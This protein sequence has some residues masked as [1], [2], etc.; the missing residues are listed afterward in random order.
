MLLFTAN[1]Y[2]ANSKTDFPKYSKELT[3]S[4]NC[5]CSGAFTSCSASGTCTC[6]CGYFTCSCTTEKQVEAIAKNEID[7]SISEKQFKNIEKLA[8]KLHEVK[9]D[10]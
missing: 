5:S 7:I 1:F 8:E 9:A 6:S 2:L 3:K 10:A 4:F